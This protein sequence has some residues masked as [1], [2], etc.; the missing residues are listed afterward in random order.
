MG[1]RW[2]GITTAAVAAAIGLSLLLLCGNGQPSSQNETGKATNAATHISATELSVDD[3]IAFE[4]NW[5]KSEYE[6]KQKLNKE[7]PNI[8]SYRPTMPKCEQCSDLELLLLYERILNF[9]EGRD[10]IYT[11]IPR[12]VK[13]ASC[14]TRDNAA[15]ERKL[16]EI[17][18]EYENKFDRPAPWWWICS[19]EERIKRLEEAIKTN[20]EYAYYIGAQSKEAYNEGKVMGTYEMWFKR[21]FSETMSFC[22]YGGRLKHAEQAIE[23][24]LPYRSESEDDALKNKLRTGYEKKFARPI[25]EDLLSIERIHY[26]RDLTY[27]YVEDI[28]LTRTTSGGAVARY[29]CGSSYRTAYT[30]ELGM[31]EWLDVINDL[32]RFDVI[33]K[34]EKTLSSQDGSMKKLTVFYLNTK[35]EHYLVSDRSRYCVDDIKTRCVVTFGSDPSREFER[36]INN[37]KA[38]IEKKG[39]KSDDY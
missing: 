24:G 29:V 34:W 31:S 19:V 39:K 12:V 30:L 33:N 6:F 11:P 37:M 1:R 18:A 25:A 20:I 36:V 9:E 16:K 27:G 13:G 26:H 8:S 4:L 2:G 38:H 3:I 17:E 21:Q 14:H 32:D 23:A 28:S 5:A 10:L 7:T 15:I 35:R 22:H